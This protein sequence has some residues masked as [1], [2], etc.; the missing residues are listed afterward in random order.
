MAAGK[1]SIDPFDALLR[2]I[3]RIGEKII[4][5]SPSE[6]FYN[7][8]LSPAFRAVEVMADQVG[9]FFEAFLIHCCLPVG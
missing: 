5:L 4:K 6:R 8:I 1:L 3:F 9:Q 2:I 7:T